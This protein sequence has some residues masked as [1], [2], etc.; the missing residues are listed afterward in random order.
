VVNGA[1]GVVDEDRAGDADLVPQTPRRR[2][3]LLEAGVRG[4]VL[5]GMRLACV[6][7]VPAEAGMPFGE[8]IEQRTLCGAV[9]SGEGAELEHD[10]ALAP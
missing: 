10:G 2:E 8:L 7:E 1:A 9:R 5:S 6:D 3:L 4:E